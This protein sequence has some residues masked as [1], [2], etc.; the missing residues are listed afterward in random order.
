MGT[1]DIKAALP[2]GLLTDVEA[3]LGVTWQSDITDSQYANWIA[4]GIDYLN[5]KRGAPADYTQPGTP[6]TLLFE[7]VRYARDSGLD[8][9]EQNYR[10]LILAMQHERRLTAYARQ[11]GKTFSP[12]C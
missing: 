2:A 8:V 12:P 10:H 1:T 9:F 3:Q 4:G 5:D 7:Y 6:R 11:N